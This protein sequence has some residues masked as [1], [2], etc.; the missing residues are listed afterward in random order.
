MVLYAVVRR[1]VDL[2][3]WIAP[4]GQTWSQMRSILFVCTGNVF[5]SVAAEYALRSL[6]SNSSQYLVGSAGTEAKPQPVHEWIT[7]CLGQK[8]ADVSA[9]R[10]RRLTEELL[11]QTDLI[12]AM[13]R[14]H[15]DFIRRTFGRHV[16][17][18]KELCYGLDEPILDLHE[19]HPDWEQDLARARLYV[20]SVI[21]MIWHD[22]PFFLDQLARPDFGT[23]RA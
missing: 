8:G 12:V 16:P 18:F 22:I 10:P 14:D 6:L 15:R 1:S 20:S 7:H 19:M 4:Q 21:E 23:T 11:H 2:V 17:L 3:R 9:H 5:R 13:S